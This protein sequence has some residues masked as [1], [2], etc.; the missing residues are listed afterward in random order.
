MKEIITSS[1]IATSKT[2]E[3]Q[4]KNLSEILQFEIDC[5]LL[6]EFLNEDICKSEE[7]KDL[8][9][10]LIKIT[11]PCVYWY[12]IASDNS[13]Y[14]IVDA[15]EAYKNDAFRN[16]AIPALKTRKRINFNSEFL[17]VGKVKRNFYGRVIQHLGCFSVPQTQGLQL[18]YWAKEIKLK[19]ELNVVEF[20]RSMENLLPIIELEIA[21]RIHPLIGKHK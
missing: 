20:D 21:D 4:S 5:S 18:Y 9:E 17:Y 7:F 16:R 11:G 14:Q 13:G 19:L 15:F 1:L 3:I 8:L 12:K 6:R 2:L 10:K